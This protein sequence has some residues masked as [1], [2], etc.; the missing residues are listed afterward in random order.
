MKLFDY[1]IIILFGLTL[2]VYLIYIEV[3]HL[4][5]KVYK[6]EKDIMEHKK[7]MLQISK[8]PP[9]PR[10]ILSSQTPPTQPRQILSPQ[11]PPTQPRQILSPPTPPTPPTEPRQIL[12]SP[13]LRPQILNPPKIE[14]CSIL[15]KL[16]NNVQIETK[17]DNETDSD[18]SIHL[19]IYSNDCDQSPLLESES[20]EHKFDYNENTTILNDEII[21]KS[22]KIQDLDEIPRILESDE[23]TKTIEEKVLHNKKSLELLKLPEVKIIAESNNISLTKTINGNVKNKTKH[24]L[25]EE[26]LNTQ[27]NN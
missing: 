7:H 24:E 27:I 12:S 9:Q 11:T 26:I 20:G 5:T 6:L 22:P 21:N 23:S 3:E 15:H 19:A 25:I 13:T 8:S 2:V 17:S 1:K 18:S 4:H 10:Q 14:N 16:I